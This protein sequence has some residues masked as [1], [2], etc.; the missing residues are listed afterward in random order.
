MR[1]SCIRLLEHLTAH[2]CCTGRSQV[3]PLMLVVSVATGFYYFSPQA[4]RFAHHRDVREE[5]LREARVRMQNSDSTPGVPRVLFLCLGQP[6]LM[7][8]VGSDTNCAEGG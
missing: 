1:T 8:A 6:L 7:P 2:C 3:V 4:Q 5:M